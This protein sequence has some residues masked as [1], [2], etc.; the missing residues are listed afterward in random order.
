MP[1]YASSLLKISADKQLASQYQQVDINH[2]ASIQFGQLVEIN[3][4]YKNKEHAEKV[5]T[6][7]FDYVLIEDA[8]KSWVRENIMN[9]IFEQV[10]NK[11]IQK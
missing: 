1:G 3:L 9:A 6:S 7:G 10:Q 5:A 4:K 11:K 8:D 2:A